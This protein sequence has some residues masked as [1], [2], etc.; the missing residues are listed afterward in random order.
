MKN[1]FKFALLTLI[2]LVI[3]Y[4]IAKGLHLTDPYI[5]YFIDISII[6]VFQVIYCRKEQVGSKELFISGSILSIGYAMFKYFEI[7]YVDVNL[8]DDFMVE[9]SRE[10]EKYGMNENEINANLNTIE[11]LIN[12]NS[13][14]IYTAV[15]VFLNMLTS[16]WCVQIW[17]KMQKKKSERTIA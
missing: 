12:A 16:L 5:N 6:A 4:F 3:Y 14:P 7:N 8:I 11:R 13:W 1:N 2:S 9:I 17:N 15:G 10:Y